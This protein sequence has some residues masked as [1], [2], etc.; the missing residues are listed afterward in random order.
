[1]INRKFVIEKIKLIIGALDHLNGFADMAFTEVAADYM[2]Y[3]ALKNILMETIGRAI[4]INE[5]LIAEVAG[6]KTEMPKTY[7]EGFSILG[8]MGIIPP[9][10]AKEIAKSAGFR[11]AIVHEYNNLDKSAVYRT[12]GQA[13]EQYKLYCDYVMKYIDENRGF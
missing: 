2:K 3:S 11:N 6:E 10:F 9:D 13:I 4:D 8:K 1:M 7:R 12:V 5:H